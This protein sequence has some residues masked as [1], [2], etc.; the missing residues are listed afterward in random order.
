[1]RVHADRGRDW[2]LIT[3]ATSFVTEVVDTPNPLI[4]LADA[5]LNSGVQYQ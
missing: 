4:Y 3:S 1:M 5:S 2:L